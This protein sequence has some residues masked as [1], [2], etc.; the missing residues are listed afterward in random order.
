MAATAKSSVAD[1]I[2]FRELAALCDT[3]AK[4]PVKEKK[5]STLAL[6]LKRWRN[7]YDRI[8]P[9]HPQP[10]P[11]TFFP[12][13]RLLMPWAD[14]ERPVYGIK[15]NT[16]AR[17]YIEELGLTPSGEPAQQLLHW[18]K[19]KPRNAG[20][21]D[22]VSDFAGVA[23]YVLQNRLHKEGEISVEAVNNHLNNIAEANAI[24]GQERK[25]T[26]KMS[27]HTLL[28]RT[29]PLEQKWLIR[30]IMKDLKFGMGED[31][32]LNV[33][34]PDAKDLYDVTS[35]ISTVC[36][37]LHDPTLRLSEIEVSLFA[38]VR[39]M[40]AET[41]NPEKLRSALKGGV[42]YAEIKYD[43]DRCQIHKNGKEF[44]YFSRGGNDN[45]NVLGSSASEGTLT[46]HIAD[47][48]RPD[49]DNFIIDGEI[50]AYGLK[51]K[52]ICTK[53]ESYSIKNLTG[54]TGYQVCFVAF[55]VLLT[56]NKTVTALPLRQRVEILKDM[57]QEDEGRLYLARRKEVST[58]DECYEFLNEA[59]D[60]NEEGIMLKDPSSVYK[61]NA[62]SAGWWKVK[63]E[64]VD[65]LSDQLDVL[66]VGAYYGTGRRSAGPSHFLLAVAQDPETPG[67]KPTKF[68][69]FSKV[70]SGYT[71]KEL[72]EMG[73]R[74]NPHFKKWT[75]TS[76]P[77]YLQLAPGEKN[78]ADLWV[79]PENSFIV[80]VS[81][82]Q[83]LDSDQFA[84]KCTL[85]FPRMKEPRYDKPWFECLTVSQLQKLKEET[86]GRLGGRNITDEDVGDG[87]GKKRPR[88][89][90]TVIRL[91]EQFR[92]ADL[93]EIQ[94]ESGIFT[95]KSFYV[96]DGDELHSKQDLERIIAENGGTCVQS[97][98]TGTFCIV[99]RK[100]TIHVRNAI[101][102]LPVDVVYP[103]WIVRCV[104][105]KKLCVWQA[106]DLLHAKPATK[107][108]INSAFDDWGDSYTEDVTV[109]QVENLFTTLLGKVE[110]I[111]R[112]VLAEFEQEYFPGVK[113]PGIFRLINAHI[114]KFQEFNDESTPSATKTILG[115]AGDLIEILGGEISDELSGKHISHV[116]VAANGSSGRLERLK[117]AN[118]SRKRKFHIVT[119]KWV[120]DSISREKILDEKGYVVRDYVQRP[121]PV[122]QSAFDGLFDV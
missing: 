98:D 17:L 19:N 80:T 60:R 18:K 75:K 13:L 91:A 77:E 76:K 107:N 67:E 104:Q 96:A 106:S 4:L 59:I 103:S 46:Q 85:R 117:A 79:E 100:L 68:L 29:D 62:R 43:G 8:Y 115:V 42:Y 56:N 74:L 93:A 3:L 53:A 61:P 25:D 95:G 94:A 120:F 89:N 35:S 109:E 55:D 24:G 69:S 27:L 7:E 70:G 71:Y 22:D 83:V 41:W 38:P 20:S 105:E 31:A 54:E 2:Q 66:V 57:F 112:D 15:E 52:C 36:T 32:I 92:P 113:L 37:K 87:A 40:L 39:P 82:A 30:M 116:V 122:Q 99:C 111:E 16:L 114:D 121:A 1:T 47:C 44:R 23:Y 101:R 6:F 28:R 72:D 9:N 26:I 49:L 110:P 10:P 78:R 12:F 86:S 97:P 65:S 45:T 48:F 84:T 11:E 14:K 88:V 21:K 51:E 33:F 50:V 63:P 34:H 58:P 108:L 90:K 119:E 102:R 118:H 81:A 64:Y 5:R 73:A